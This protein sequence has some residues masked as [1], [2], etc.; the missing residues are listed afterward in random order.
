MLKSLC[1][2]LLVMPHLA[3]AD[4]WDAL[5][6]PGTIGV[7]RHALAP[8]TGDPAGF[9]LGDCATQ[10][11][12]DAQGQAQ[13]RKIGAALRENA[14]VFDQVLTSQWCRTSETARL[15]TAGPVIETPALNSFFEDYTTRAQQTHD[16]L[17]VLSKTKGKL[18]LVTHQVNITALTGQT[19]RSGEVIVIR[20]TDDG[21]QMVDRIHIAP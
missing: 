11:N 10:R 5:R 14:I 17:D 8:G 9:R 16:V 6:A 7:M 21:P 4:G 3:L 2:V 1:L 15:L 20:L 19:P 18:M 12:L 13:A